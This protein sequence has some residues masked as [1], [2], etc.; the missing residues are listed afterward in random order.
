MSTDA[1]TIDELEDWVRS[2][3][4]WQVLDISNQQ[5][6]VEFRTCTGE[7]MDRR[8]T[9]DSNVIGYLRTAHTDLDPT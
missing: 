6:E 7:P 4:H 2:G 9:H 8:R 5:A 1:L 3:G